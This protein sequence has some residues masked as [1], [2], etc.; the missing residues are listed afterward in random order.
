MSKRKHYSITEFGIITKNDI[1]QEESQ[2]NII[3][4]DEKEFEQIE[5]FILENRSDEPDLSDLLTIT[6]RKPYNKVIQAKNYVGLI[7]TRNRTLIEILPKI[8]GISKDNPE[9]NLNETRYLFLRMLKT[10]K[11]SP[12]KEFSS[13]NLKSCKM[14][15]F[16]VFISKFLDE[17]ELLI[18]KG[19]CG[20]YINNQQNSNVLKGR[21]IFPVHIR[22]NIVHRERFFI[23]YDEFNYNR[24][25]NKLIKRTLALLLN[26]SSSSHNQKRIKE[27]LIIFDT[28]DYSRNIDKDLSKC[29]PNRLTEDYLLILEW[30]KIFLK[31]KSFS[32]YRGESIALAL[33]F[34]MEQ[35]FESYL[36]YFFQYNFSG[37]DMIYLQGSGLHGYLAQEQHPIDRKIFYLKPDITAENEENITIIDAKWKLLDENDSEKK[38]KISQ[39]DFYQLFAY[40]KIY[41]NIK[42]KRINLVLIYPKNDNFQNPISFTYKDVNKISMK[43]IPFDIKKSLDDSSSYSKELRQQLFNN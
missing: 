24:P 30:C 35:I 4:I 9:D 32:N 29:N 22:E 13:T 31:R 6:C 20:A 17:V 43:V 28:I 34:P 5:Q 23:S 40:G 16:E 14:P 7:E 18:K 36:S 10:L 25:E 37:W 2:K 19:I 3:H 42:S 15:L 11:N 8:W 12:F 41:E 33:L 39:M 38:Y 27:A 21:L 26:E 1:S